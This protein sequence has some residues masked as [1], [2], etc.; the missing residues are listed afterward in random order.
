[1]KK[2]VRCAGISDL[3]AMA[4]EQDV[5]GILDAQPTNRVL[6]GSADSD[7][8]QEWSAPATFRG[9]SCTVYYLF[10]DEEVA[11]AGEDA[12]DLPWDWD[13]VSRIILDGGETLGT[14]FASVIDGKWDMR[15]DDI[16]VQL[17]ADPSSDVDSPCMIDSEM[18]EW[19]VL[20]L[21]TWLGLCL[22][23]DADGL[24]WAKEE[25]K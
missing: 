23:Q 12:G 11:E 6:D 9:H 18:D 17:L 5:Q 8:A 20:E 21:C 16:R 24:W 2:E 10:D 15:R 25:A 22:E 19:T 13:H 4:D 1:M 3:L 7:Y 14:I